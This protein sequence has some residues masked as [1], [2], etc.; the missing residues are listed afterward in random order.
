[1]HNYENIDKLLVKESNGT[2]QKL[3]NNV[4]ELSAFAKQ[5][6]TRSKFIKDLD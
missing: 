3:I 2:L 4:S 6:E 5:T 1:M